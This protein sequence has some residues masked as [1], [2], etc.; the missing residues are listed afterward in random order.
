MALPESRGTHDRIS[1][2]RCQE[3][4]VLRDKVMRPGGSDG[5]NQRAKD[6]LVEVV[7]QFGIV[8]F[9]WL[10]DFGLEREDV[11]QF[12]DFGILQPVA[13]DKAGKDS[14]QFFKKRLRENHLYFSPAP[15]GKNPAGY[16]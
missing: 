4:F 16:A 12:V 1:V 10:D 2:R 14:S 9:C 13:V 15:G 6:R 7:A 3:I 11:D 8:P 5:L